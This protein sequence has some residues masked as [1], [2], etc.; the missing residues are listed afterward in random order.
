MRTIKLIVV[1]KKRNRKTYWILIQVWMIRNFK[2]LNIKGHHFLRDFK[3]P[4]QVTV[5]T[6]FINDCQSLKAMIGNRYDE[7]NYHEICNKSSFHSM[8]KRWKSMSNQ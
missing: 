1:K 4:S 6:K 2:Y 3:G 8:L 5:Q 7:Q